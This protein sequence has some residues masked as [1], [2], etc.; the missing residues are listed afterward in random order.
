[1]SETIAQIFGGIFWG[2]I[3]GGYVVWF[4]GRIK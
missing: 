4:W 1:M 2:S 3:I